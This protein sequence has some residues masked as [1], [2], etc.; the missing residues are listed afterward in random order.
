M[1]QKNFSPQDLVGQDLLNDALKFGETVKHLRIAAKWNQ[2]ELADRIGVTRQ[3]ISS[4]ENGSA[5]PSKTIGIALSAVF[6]EYQNSVES[7]DLFNIICENT[8]FSKA[9]AG[10]LGGKLGWNL[11]GPIGA[12]IGTTAGAAIKHLKKD[13]K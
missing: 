13:K 5:R 8:G 10:L 3:T 2:D 9:S 12:I 7:N 4:I 6:K 1:E 11:G